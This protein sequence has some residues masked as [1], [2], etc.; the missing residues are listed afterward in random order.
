[1]I[2]RHKFKKGHYA[3]M[4]LTRD[5]LE[6]DFRKSNV[7]FSAFEEVRTTL[8]ASNFTYKRSPHIF[9]IWCDFD[10]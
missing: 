2:L 10:F 1:M 3:E 4:F 8:V 5:I 6:Q 7:S 9:N